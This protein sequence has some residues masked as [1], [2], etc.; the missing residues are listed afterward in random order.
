M[1][2]MQKANKKVHIWRM[3]Y[4]PLVLFLYNFLVS[5]AGGAFSLV[6]SISISTKRK[7]NGAIKHTTTTKEVEENCSNTIISGV[8]YSNA[9]MLPLCTNIYCV[10]GW[11]IFRL[12]AYVRSL[13]F[14][15]TRNSFGRCWRV[16]FSLVR[17]AKNT[18]FPRKQIKK[19]LKTFGSIL[20][21]F[22][23][24]EWWCVRSTLCP[25]KCVHYYYYYCC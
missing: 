5:G 23:V 25:C 18:N 9:F 3:E 21:C 7:C 10:S 19:I 16:F 22:I 12:H 13:H 15:C 2:N 17:F 24:N 11:L 6:L 1:K 4:F 8:Y 14:Q 20:I